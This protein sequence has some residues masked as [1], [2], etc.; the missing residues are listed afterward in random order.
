MSQ[1]RFDAAESSFWGTAFVALASLGG[2]ALLV[3]SL[4]AG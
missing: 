1:P 4:I 2:T 3:L